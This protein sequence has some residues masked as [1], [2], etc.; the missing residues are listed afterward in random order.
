MKVR[1]ITVFAILALVL[2]AAALFAAASAPFVAPDPAAK[3]VTVA[4]KASTA[5]VD[6]SDITV[7]AQQNVTLNVTAVDSKVT[8]KLD[9][10][11]INATIDKGKTETFKFNANKI[12]NYPFKAGTHS[13]AFKV[14]TKT[15]K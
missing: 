11:K 1:L 4:I 3:D 7:Y 5:S 2:G 9:Q 10:F 8:F 6:P 15:S 12:G 14:V 13:G